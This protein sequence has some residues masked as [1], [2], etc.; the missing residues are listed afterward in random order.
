MSLLDQLE[1]VLAEERTALLQGN[2]LGL[3]TCVEA[4][5]SLSDALLK[6]ESVQLGADRAHALRRRVL[7][8]AELA[9]TLSRQLRAILAQGHPP[10]STYTSHGRQQMR[11]PLAVVSMRG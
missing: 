1:H 2:W 10:L 4:K 11:R 6:D 9:S 8:N 5:Q 7:H 3:Q